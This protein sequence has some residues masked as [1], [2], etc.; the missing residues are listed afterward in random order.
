MSA[1]PCVLNFAAV[2]LLLLTDPGAC[3]G[4]SLK[5]LGRA[6]KFS[7]RFELVLQGA[8]GGP[9]QDFQISLPGTVKDMPRGGSVFRNADASIV[10]V[11]MK[12]ATQVN[13]I[14]LFLQREG[15]LLF[16]PM[17]NGPLA[18]IL[19]RLG[20]HFPPEELYLTGLEGRELEITYDAFDKEKAPLSRKVYRFAV[21][22]DGTITPR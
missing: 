4:V 19:E 8:A 5:P 12:P 13:H 20:V 11:N 3:A 9:D 15:G 6:E 22:Q 17:A 7:T 14:Y 1:T 16:L 21:D 10:A 2:A 18:R